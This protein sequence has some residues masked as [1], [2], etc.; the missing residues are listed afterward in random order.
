MNIHSVFNELVINSFRHVIEILQT[1]GPRVLLAVAVVLLGWV[2]A[3]IIRKII[4]KLLRLFG[5]DVFAEKF[6]I[7]GLLQRGEIKRSPSSLAGKLFFWL[8]IINSFIMASDIM[9]LGFTTRLFHRIFVYLPKIA[10]TIII[11]AIGIVIGKFIDRFVYKTALIA[12]FP[13]SYIAGKIA[14]FMIFGIIFLISLE[15]LEVSR[16]I[17]VQ[18][19]IIIISA[20]PLFLFITFSIGGKDIISNVSASKLIQKEY[21][22]GDSIKAGDFYGEIISINYYAVKLKN[23][24]TELLIPN[25]LFIQMAVEKKTG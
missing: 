21:K 7:T 9:N 12:K 18:F 15:Y 2:F 10:V 11:L 16:H 25:S 6:G 3:V 17:S 24:K 4:A 13:F 1:Y 5:F 20:V 8:I 14:A 23:K 22:I 19:S